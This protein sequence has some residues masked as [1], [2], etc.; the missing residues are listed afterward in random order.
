MG[1]AKGNPRTGGYGHRT[2][3]WPTTGIES[4]E[5]FSPHQ[6]LIMRME[7]LSVIVALEM[8]KPN[9]SGC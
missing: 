7:L 1:S 3:K 5:G 8:L 4:P 6:Q 9:L 2:F